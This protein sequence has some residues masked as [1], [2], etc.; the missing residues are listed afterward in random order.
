MIQLLVRWIISAVL[1]LVVS[2]LVPGFEVDGLRSALI[3]AF[4]IGLVNATLGTLLKLLTLPL[5]LLSLGLFLLV[6]NAL[7][8]MF[9]S[10]FVHGF[11]VHGFVPAFCGALL[12]S[13]LGMVTRW[14]T[15]SGN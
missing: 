14:L 13:I 1:L 5:T 6:I 11:I 3:A 8:L 12:L 10:H 15:P 7:M 9:A 4:V 2:R